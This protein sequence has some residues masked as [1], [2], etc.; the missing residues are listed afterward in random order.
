MQTDVINSFNKNVGTNIKVRRT[1]LKW[2]QERLA[3]KLGVTFQQ[4]QKYEKGTNGCSGYR[5]DQLSSIMKKPVNYFFEKPVLA[6]EYNTD[7]P[8]ILTED[9][10]V[11]DDQSSSR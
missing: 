6:L 10:E 1:E 2:T 5:L 7:A 11:K 9:M 3:K 4:V 8:L